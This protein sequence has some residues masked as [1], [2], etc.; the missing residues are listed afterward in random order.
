MKS[1]FGKPGDLCILN[2]KDCHDSGLS[3]S[4]WEKVSYGEEVLNVKR[5]HEKKYI[6][7]TGA[8]FDYEKEKAYAGMA[9][10][11]QGMDLVAVVS[12]GTNVWELKVTGPLVNESWSNIGVRW[13][14]N[15]D[16]PNIPL[17][18]SGGLELYVDAEKVGH[19]I[20]PL[21][22]PKNRGSWIEADVLA[23]NDQQSGWNGLMEHKPPL[24]MVGCHRNSDMNHFDYFNPI[25][26]AFD[27][28]TIWT[29]KLVQNKTVDEI[30]YFMSGYGNL[31]KP[32][33]Q[34]IE[35]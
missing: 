16:D 26:T 34:N 15:K 28:L 8:D 14:P 32:L 18:E 12:D 23:P 30:L 2:P 35:N 10:F 22:K 5:Q 33:M 19:A 11:H 24:L 31:E 27:E 1:D 4:I 25:K 9:L 29:R 13:E 7:S 20:F 6:F 17:T 3:F 21:D